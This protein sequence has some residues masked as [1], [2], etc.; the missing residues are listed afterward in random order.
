MPFRSNQDA[1]GSSQAVNATGQLGE[2]KFIRSKSGSSSQTLVGGSGA[3]ET[4]PTSA[5]APAFN[6]WTSITDADAVRARVD[7]DR[8]RLA[9]L[10]SPPGTRETVSDL[11]ASPR[12]H[13]KYHHAASQPDAESVLPHVSATQPHGSTIR[14]VQSQPDSGLPMSDHAATYLNQ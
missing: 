9:G 12:G 4:Q 7:R 8:A 14:G 5:R 10:H 1:P 6:P 3:H 11:P 13:Q 2:A